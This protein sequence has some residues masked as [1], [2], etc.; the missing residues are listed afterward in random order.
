MALAGALLLLMAL[1]SAYLRNLPISTSAIY[2]ALGL[3]IGPLGFD[4][5]RIDLRDEVRWFERLTEVAVIVALFVGGLRLR[6]P[7]RDPAWIAARRLGGPIMLASIVGVAFCAMLLFGL[8]TGTALLVGAVLAPTDPVLA[9]TVKV[10]SAAD[11][12]RMRYGLSGEAGLNDGMAFP[13]VVF[14]LLWAEHGGAGGW[15]TGWALHR[16]LWAVPAGLLLGFILGRGV[17]RLAIWL[18]S[19]QQDKGAPSD[20]LALALIALSYVGAEVIGAWGFLATFAA[21][22]GLRHAELH[23]SREAPYRDQARTIRQRNES[24]APD[25]R[26]PAEELVGASV[27]AEALK[28]PTVA[29]GVLVAETISFG[30]TAERLLEIMLVV[31]VGV[32]LASHWD[33]RAVPLALVLF[34]LIRP[35]ATRVMLA[36][37]PTTN[38]QRW[39]MGW[40]GIRGIGSLYYLSYALT[41]GLTGGAAADVVGLTISVVALSILV[42]GMSA[43]PLLARFEKGLSRA[44][45]G[46]N[47]AE[48]A[49]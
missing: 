23:V 21:G 27:A 3:A 16:L 29:A 1:S 30:D 20:F 6:L 46:G 11:H 18:R 4:W 40:F 25:S 31:L 17:G 45:D 43:R 41:H 34:F 38:A 14:A 19:R 36:G 26:P 35:L 44:S 32:L 5:L 39:L 8:D 15:I 13:F 42:H 48:A 47:T 2:L 24:P 10:N 22:V 9:G 49:A 7:L 33:P 28:E 12:D 37:T